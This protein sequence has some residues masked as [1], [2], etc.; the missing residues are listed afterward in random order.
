MG[1][2]QVFLDPSGDWII[3]G[4]VEFDSASGAHLKLPQGT[5]FPADPE[6]GDFFFRTDGLK[7]YRYSGSAWQEQL[8]SVGPHRLTHEPGGSDALAVDATAGTGSLRTLGTGAQQACAG[9]DSRLSDARTPT[10]HA[11]SHENGGA[12]E[13][14]VAGLSG[15]LADP[16][17]PSTHASTH[18]GGGADSI[19]L[20]DLA[21][22][23]D[24]TDLDSTTLRH[25]LLPKLGGGTTDYLRADGSWATP[26]GGGSGGPRTFHAEIKADGSLGTGAFYD[27]P[28]GN[29]PSG[30]WSGWTSADPYVIPFDCKL[31]R[32]V[33]AAV[34]GSFDWRSSPG[35]LFSGLE[36]RSH[37]Y[38]GTSSLA[39]FSLELVGS[40]TGGSF[41]AGPQWVVDGSSIVL[42][43]GANLFPRGSI[44]G[45]LHASI[46][47][48]PGRIYNWT[49]P[50]IS[51]EF[52]EV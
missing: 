5:S 44:V 36:L 21:A 35:S 11:T 24:N 32:A 1:I 31:V 52:E 45:L 16:Q 14:S 28:P 10:A 29:S 15:A 17:T 7:L 19:K 12:D 3:T 39:V 43:S 50:L 48:T 9:S 40:Y 34:S 23:D 4:H 20:D 51:L 22:P 41:S 33:V 38:N 2:V 27:R 42:V 30:S 18:Q 47:S 8:V 6:A 49:D 26:P 37:A 46:S 13:I 25:G